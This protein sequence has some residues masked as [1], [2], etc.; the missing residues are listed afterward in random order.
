MIGLIRFIIPYFPRLRQDWTALSGGEGCTG[1]KHSEH[2]SGQGPSGEG[3]G[4]AKQILP[5]I[6]CSSRDIIGIGRPEQ[7]AGR[8][9]LP[10]DAKVQAKYLVGGTLRCLRKHWPAWGCVPSDTRRAPGQLPQGACLW[11]FII[12]SGYNCSN[13]P[14]YW[15]LP[16]WLP[17]SSFLYS[18]FRMSSRHAWTNASCASFSACTFSRRSFS[19]FPASPQLCSLHGF[20]LCRKLSC[21]AR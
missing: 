19:Y 6:A 17:A 14:A 8:P 4:F 10:Y 11:P 12:D 13:L 2:G 9:C 3:W 20:P 15:L 1:A 18:I 16:L 21:Q 5:G 7:S